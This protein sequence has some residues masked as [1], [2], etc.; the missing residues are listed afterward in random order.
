MP[1]VIF[2]AITCSMQFSLF[3][4]SGGMGLWFTYLSNQIS[5]SQRAT[6]TLCDILRSSNNAFI[7]STNDT[8]CVDTISD[9][10]IQDSTITGISY[11]VT[12]FL[13][14]VF[15]HRVGKGYILLVTLFGGTLA[16]YSLYWITNPN[17]AIVL[18]SL[19]LVLSG[20]S[21]SLVTG[22]SINLFSTTVRSSAICVMLMAGRL[23]ISFGTSI[24]GTTIQTHCE[25]TF[26]VLNT[27]VLSKFYLFAWMGKIKN[28]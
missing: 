19:M 3:L 9:K 10:A 4:V 16:G 22:S 17:V 20:S 21:V 6:G 8:T 5:Q 1:Y 13:I 24:I 27:F 11:T 2:L 28:A 18:F 25:E 7:N 12:L 26:F 15:V 23:A 14:A